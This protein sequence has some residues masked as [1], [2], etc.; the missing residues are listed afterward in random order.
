MLA[1]Q[2]YGVAWLV[3]LLSVIGLLVV[4]WRLF[5]GVPSAYLRRVISL[6][7][8][9]FFVT[10][11]LDETT[12]WAPAWIVGF[13]EFLFAGLDGLVPILQILLIVWI[14]VIVLYTLIKLLFFRGQK[15]TP[16]KKAKI[17]RRVNK[18]RVSPTIS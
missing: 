3:Y 17:P 7:V 6:T 12:Y 11:V 15:S 1:F 9:V 2:E 4:S 8:C 13:L 14:V 5:R 18:K 16:R 10:P